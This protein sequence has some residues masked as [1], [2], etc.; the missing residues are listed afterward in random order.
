MRI[1]L[2]EMPYIA[3]SALHVHEQHV[4]M[5]MLRNQ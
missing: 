3:Y 4:M 5:R 2:H 1:I